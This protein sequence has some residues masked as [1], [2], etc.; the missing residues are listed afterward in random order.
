MHGQQNIKII[1]LCFD[2]LFRPSSGKW[3]WPQ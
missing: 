1:I 3:R 2:H